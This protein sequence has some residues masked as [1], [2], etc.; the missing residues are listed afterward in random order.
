MNKFQLILSDLEKALQHVGLFLAFLAVPRIATRQEFRPP[1]M[2]QAVGDCRYQAG[3]RMRVSRQADGVCYSNVW[4]AGL[5]MFE[6]VPNFVALC[7]VI[8]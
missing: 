3:T 8:G 4:G 1:E 5:G 7:L 6:R 2:P